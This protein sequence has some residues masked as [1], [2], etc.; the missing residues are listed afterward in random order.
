MTEIDHVAEADRL[1][2]ATSGR[3]W[4]EKAPYLD[5]ILQAAQTHALLA[6]VATQGESTSSTESK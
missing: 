4:S 2:G 1:L 3:D 6:L 5:R